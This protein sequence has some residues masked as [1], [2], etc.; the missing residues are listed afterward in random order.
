MAVAGQAAGWSWADAAI[1]AD[2]GTPNQTVP[3]KLDFGDG[4][5]RSAGTTV[6]DS[7]SFRGREYIRHE[8]SNNV[9][10]RPRS[11]TLTPYIGTILLGKRVFG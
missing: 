10:D 4:V 3:Y 8:N 6:I 11:V 5:F 1:S 7:N 9:I 2:S